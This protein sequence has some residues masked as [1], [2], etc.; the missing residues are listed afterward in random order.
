MLLPGFLGESGLSLVGIFV[1]V[2]DTVSLFTFLSTAAFW[3]VILAVWAVSHL[4]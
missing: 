2:A 3:A 1:A 4:P